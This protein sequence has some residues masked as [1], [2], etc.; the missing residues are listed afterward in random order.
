M[1]NLSTSNQN[2]PGIISGSGGS[3][4]GVYIQDKKDILYKE[5]DNFTPLNFGNFPPKG[6]IEYLAY[7]A[8]N[9]DRYAKQL[10]YLYTMLIYDAI[11]KVDEDVAARLC[12][13]TEELVIMTSQSSRN[14]KKLMDENNEN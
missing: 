10:R 5:P 6:Q 12:S 4:E 9:A 14:A 2:T 1:R 11:R 8:S 7:T 3:S 13:L